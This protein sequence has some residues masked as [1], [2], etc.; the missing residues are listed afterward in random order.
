VT[1]ES[2]FELG[3]E[4]SDWG[5]FYSLGL[6]VSIHEEPGFKVGLAA[7]Y[8]QQQNKDMGLISIAGFGYDTE[9]MPRLPAAGGDVD[10]YL[11][12]G[13]G[14][15]AAESTTTEMALALVLSGSMGNFSPYGGVK[16]STMKTDY[17]G[18]V[19]VWVEQ[20]EGDEIIFSDSEP[21]LDF[22]FSTVQADSLGMF[23][24]GTYQFNDSISGNIELQIFDEVGVSTGL[25]I[26][27]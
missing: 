16:Y 21:L 2:P 25:S 13:L 8:A 10:D 24:G 9:P 27:L 19:Y 17:T 1:L 12:I 15:E 5:P 18:R 20:M 22:P 7:Q 26:G 4:R 6:K 11:E 14:L 23:A 3:F